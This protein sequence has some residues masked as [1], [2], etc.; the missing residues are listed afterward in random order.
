MRYK[1]LDNGKTNTQT[2][3]RKAP[4]GRDHGS[5]LAIAGKPILHR[6]AQCN[7]KDRMNSY[8]KILRDLPEHAPE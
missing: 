1:K 4:V 3:L 8:R 2:V 5:K 6:P 7:A